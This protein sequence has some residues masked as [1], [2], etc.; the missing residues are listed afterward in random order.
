MGNRKRR[1]QRLHCLHP[2]WKGMTLLCLPALSFP[3][4]WLFFSLLLPFLFTHL[5]IK[6]SYRSHPLFIVTSDFSFI[7]SHSVSCFLFILASLGVHIAVNQACSS[8]HWLPATLSPM[9]RFNSHIWVPTHSHTHTQGR[10]ET[11]QHLKIVQSP[12]ILNQTQ[13]NQMVYAH[14]IWFCTTVLSKE[15]F[16]WNLLDVK[17]LNSAFQSPILL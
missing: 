9:S 14:E 11:L 2:K 8:T 7:I 10:N 17:K 13:T 3:P 15:I 4:H 6:F 1:C 5:L 16:S 12:H